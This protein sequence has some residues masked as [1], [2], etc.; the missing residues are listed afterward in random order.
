L[1]VEFV[2]EAL[3]E[4]EARRRWWHANRDERELFDA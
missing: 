3:E 4:L 2:P 1:R